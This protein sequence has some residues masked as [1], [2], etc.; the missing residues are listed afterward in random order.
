MMMNLWQ[1]ELG[2]CMNNTE[3]SDITYWEVRRSN[4]RSGLANCCGASRKSDH[5]WTKKCVHVACAV[6]SLCFWCCLKL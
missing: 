3:V 2:T 5:G 4:M 6:G 1:D